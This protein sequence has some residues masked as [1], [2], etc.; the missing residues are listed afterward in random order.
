MSKYL[1]SWEESIWYD[2]EI[3]ADSKLEALDKFHSNEYDREDVAFVGQ[4]ITED[5]I[6]IE[7]L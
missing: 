1:I 7:E 3:E 6:E 4:V 2:L 5:T